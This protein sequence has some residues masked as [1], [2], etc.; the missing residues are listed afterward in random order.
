MLCKSQS[1]RIS[2]RHSCFAACRS[3]RALTRPASE[4]EAKIGSCRLGVRGRQA[5]SAPAPSGSKPSPRF[6]TRQS[7]KISSVS[8]ERL[9]KCCGSAETSE[10]ACVRSRAHWTSSTL[11]VWELLRLSTPRSML[12]NYAAHSRLSACVSISLMQ[13]LSFPVA[14]YPLVSYDLMRTGEKCILNSGSTR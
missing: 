13:R 1:Q 8:A 12:E 11:V 3:R 14:Q 10:L 9:I 2:M 5:T 4:V 6:T 7:E